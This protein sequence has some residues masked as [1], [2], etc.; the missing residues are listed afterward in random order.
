LYYSGEE[1]TNNEEQTQG[2][3]DPFREVFGLIAIN[4]TNKFAFSY[5]ANDGTG[6]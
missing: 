1:I 6:K 4:G 5:N 2:G 3:P